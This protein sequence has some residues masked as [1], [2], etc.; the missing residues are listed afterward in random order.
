MSETINLTPHDT[1]ILEAAIETGW[2]LASEDQSYGLGY[3][4]NCIRAAHEAAAHEIARHRSGGR[5][6]AR[7]LVAAC[8]AA[9]IAEARLLDCDHGGQA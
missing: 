7:A 4:K 1:A 6:P 9:C 3:A 5:E 2:E 8:L